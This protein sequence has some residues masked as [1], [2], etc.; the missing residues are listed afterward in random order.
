MA[1][2]L[3]ILVLAI[4]CLMLAGCDTSGGRGSSAKVDRVVDG[5]T[6][7]LTDGRRVRLVQIDAP[8]VSSGECYADRA[9]AELRR[10]IPD[11]SVVRLVAD[12]SLDQVDEHGRLL[13]YLV[14]GLRNLNVA[15]VK[16]GAAAP[17]FY[18]GD[19][20]AYAGR[21]TTAANQAKQAG[22]GLWGACPGT[23]LNPTRGVAT[24]PA[25]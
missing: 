14:V 20:G 17:Y 13:R 1:R 7:V 15:M 12:P 3:T 5:D 6:V 18:D 11:S 9:T 23:V 22:I 19:R 21:L 16:R 24:G 25:G 8:E 10:L 4:A 2:P